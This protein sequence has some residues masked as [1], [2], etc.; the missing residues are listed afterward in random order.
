MY[1]TSQHQTKVEIIVA[2]I[3]EIA[4]NIFMLK[5][6]CNIN[7]GQTITGRVAWVAVAYINEVFHNVNVP[8]FTSC[9]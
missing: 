5:Y 9:M 3:F 1:C 6:L 4:N 2:F 7:R 8:T